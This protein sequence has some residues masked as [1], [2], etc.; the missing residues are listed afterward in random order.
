MDLRVSNHLR[1]VQCRAN[2]AARSLSEKSIAAAG[3]FG[4]SSL[5]FELKTISPLDDEGI[6]VA[7]CVAGTP[8]AFGPL[9]AAQSPEDVCSGKSP[10]GY[11]SPYL[12]Q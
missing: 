5:E 1:L 4:A 11:Q 2:C 6:V 9:A 3:V 7:V 10:A 12:R 8:A